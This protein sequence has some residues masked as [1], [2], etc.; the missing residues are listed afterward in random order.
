MSIN[1]NEVVIEK[2]RKIQA[3]IEDAKNDHEAQVAMMMFQ[4]LLDKNGLT[5]SDVDAYH[6]EDETVNEV[7]VFTA[8]R[9]ATWKKLLHAYIARHFRCLPLT[10]EYVTPIYEVLGD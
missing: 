2:L 7:E 8:S 5:E 3:V 1:T 4:R 9:V 10:R 6:V